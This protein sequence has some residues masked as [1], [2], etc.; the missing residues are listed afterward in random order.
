[1]GGFFKG[2]EVFHHVGQVGGFVAAAE[3]VVELA[4][5]GVELV[6][7]LAV[8]GDSDIVFCFCYFVYAFYSYCILSVTQASA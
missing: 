8:G 3:A 2:E 6:V 4:V 5:Q 7:D 1:M